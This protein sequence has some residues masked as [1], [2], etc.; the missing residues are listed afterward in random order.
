MAVKN[1][2]NF[3]AKKLPTAAH[4]NYA[5]SLRFT[6]CSFLCL[7]FHLLQLSQKK[8]EDRKGIIAKG[9]LISKC[10]FGVIVWTKIPT[11]FF[12][13]FLPQ[14]L[15]RGQIKKQ[16]KRVKI[17]SSNQRYKVPL[18]FYLTSF[19]WCFGPNDDNKRIF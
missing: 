14:P 8:I 18:F 16:C 2:H 11:K 13:G 17:K 1:R 6:S 12:P 10:P 19:Q 5:A 9:Q 15:K 7:F 4:Q 3:R